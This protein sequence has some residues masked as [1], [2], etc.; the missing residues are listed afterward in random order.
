MPTNLFRE[1]FRDSDFF[2]ALCYGEGEKPLL[3]LI[4]ATDKKKYL[5]TNTSW[6]TKKKVNYSANFCHDFI[7]DLDE[8]PFYDYSLC[9]PANYE[10]NPAMTAYGSIPN[11]Q[12]NFHISTYR[13]CPHHCCFCSSHTVHGRKMRYHSV[14]RVRDD[15]NR[16]TT[17]YG[18]KILV[19]QDEHFMADRRRALELIE[20][21]WELNLTSIFQNGLAMYALDREVLEAFRSAGVKQMSLSMES[22]S[23]RVLQ[24]IMHK[25]LTLS[26]AKRVA[27]DCRELGIYTNTAILIGLPGETK[28][29]MEMSLSFLKKVGVNWFIVL[30][31]TPIPGS[32]MLDTCIENNY[33]KG[34]ILNCD[35][36][37]AIVETEDFTTNDIQELAYIFN[38]EL[39]FIANSD[40]RLKNYTMALKGFEN[41]IRAKSEHVFAHLAMVE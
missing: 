22:G 7:E 34:D 4:Q 36:K 41:A 13:G 25:P 10:L 5:E 37:T 8:I 6:I 26:V 21:I 35:F 30:C 31:A 3:G 12:C 40:M 2:D 9:L 15:F 38:L 23:E 18:A 17:Q 27:R 20:I 16:L 32:E 24:K 28:Q 19:F 33:L 29:D 39:N 11:T 14:A 1:F